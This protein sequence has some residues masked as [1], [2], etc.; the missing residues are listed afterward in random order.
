MMRKPTNIDEYIALFP[1]STQVLL[2]QVRSAIKKM[3]PEAE[4]V[5][6]YAMP[7]FKLE[8]ILVYF[9]AYKEHIGFYPTGSGIALFQDEISS[10]TSSKGAVQFPLDKPMPLDLISKI[11]KYRVNENIEKAK[12]KARL[13]SKSKS[14]K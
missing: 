3:A 2:E 9:A 5:I 7:A 6:S 4:E 12:L 13:K 14:K 10:Y 11:V 1:E 8:G